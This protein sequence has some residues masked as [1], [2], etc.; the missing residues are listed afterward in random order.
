MPKS[1]SK[2]ASRSKS[3]SSAGAK[4]GRAGLLKIQRAAG[5]SG[6]QKQFNK[7]IQQLDRE[8]RHLAQWR[9]AIAAYKLRYADKYQPLL[10]RY[11]E[12]Q[13]RLVFA[14]DRAHADRTFDAEDKARIADIICDV[15]GQLLAERA[16]D[17]VKQLYN[18]H[19]GGDYDAEVAE[20]EASV[21][22][23][24]LQQFGVDV[25]H[26]SPGEA[27]A[28]IAAKLRSEMLGEQAAELVAA[29]GA[30]D[31]PA[32]LASRRE[33][34]QLDQATVNALPD[35]RLRQYNDVLVGQ[36]AELRDEIENVE[37]TFKAEYDIPPFPE[38][39][40]A[41]LSLDLDD[42]LGLLEVDIE[43]LEHD[44]A[45]FPEGPYLKAWLGER[46]DQLRERDDESEM[47][48]VDDEFLRTLGGIFG[49]SR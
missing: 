20:Q 22:A 17:A 4:P 26:V 38:L 30:G 11:D 16:D 49:P 27:T 15:A 31:V 12:L 7:L 8:R 33:I 19:S 24:L 6:A 10:R 32:L 5:L 47:G 44:L 35:Q 34:E 46:H 23:M 37:I 48:D 45:L 40:A 3:K 36:I 13:T 21:A 29:Y 9:E 1:T 25:D 2:S 28:R 14:L 39:P 43:E 42:D 41:E 18:K